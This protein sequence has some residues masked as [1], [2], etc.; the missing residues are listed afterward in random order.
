MIPAFPAIGYSLE[1]PGLGGTD[2]AE[3]IPAGGGNHLMRTTST[4]TVDGLSR[5]QHT[6]RSNIE[7]GED[8]VKVRFFFF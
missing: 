5:A 3:E 1:E 8:S 6:Q 2:A 7:D 4:A